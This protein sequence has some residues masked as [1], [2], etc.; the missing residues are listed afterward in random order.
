MPVAP[1]LTARSLTH[2]THMCGCY[3]VLAREGSC[4]ALGGIQANSH[5]FGKPSLLVQSLR[6][7]TFPHL[8]AWIITPTITLPRARGHQVTHHDCQGGRRGR[9]LTAFDSLISTALRLTD[10]S[11][12]DSLTWSLSDP[13]TGTSCAL[14]SFHSLLFR[15]EGALCGPLSVVS[16]RV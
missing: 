15:S 11:A 12:T 6:T 9:S 16:G 10:S 5:A 4:L 7:D 14:S 8:G 3:H 13:S 2:S 1:V